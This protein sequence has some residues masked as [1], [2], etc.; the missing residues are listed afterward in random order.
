[1]S[2][3]GAKFWNLSARNSAPPGDFSGIWLIWL[4]MELSRSQNILP[5]K[6]IGGRRR[7]ESGENIEGDQDLRAQQS[8]V[9]SGVLASLGVNNLGVRFVGDNR[10]IHHRYSSIDT[11]SHIVI[12]VLLNN[13]LLCTK[14]TLVGRER[15]FTKQ[16]TALHLHCLHTYCIA[17]TRYCT[18][19][20][21]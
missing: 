14:T 9:L 13:S 21:T 15:D 3:F 12:V 20:V 11:H 10:R 4:S 8:C 7:E 2:E 1:M 17:R 5:P 18:A 16:R 19:L 6:N